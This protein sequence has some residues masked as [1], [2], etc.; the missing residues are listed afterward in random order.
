M[1]GVYFIPCR[2]DTTRLSVEQSGLGA[3]RVEADDKSAD[4]EGTDTA[5]LCVALLDLGDVLCDV[6]DRHRIFDSQ[7]MALG[8]DAGLVNEDTSIGVQTSESEADV[9]V[10]ETDLGGSDAR[11]L[12]LHGAALLAT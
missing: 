1:R 11:V 7:A 4:A 12:E 5:G 2:V 10:D 8:F 9:V 3:V 6:L